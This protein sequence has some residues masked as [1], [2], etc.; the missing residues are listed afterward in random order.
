MHPVVELSSLKDI[1]NLVIERV[2][3][4]TLSVNNNLLYRFINPL[5]KSVFEI[6]NFEHINP[7]LKKK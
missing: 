5:Q 1:E 2:S 3:L 6:S 4:E 7:I